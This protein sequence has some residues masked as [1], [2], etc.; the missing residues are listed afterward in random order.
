MI[1]NYFKIAWRN[2]SKNKGYSAINIGGLSVGMA[3]AMLIGLWIWDELSFDKYHKNY[4]RIAR[5]MQNQ[6]YNGEVSSQFANP[7]V[8]SREIRNKYGSDFKYVLQSSWNFQH[9][10]AYGEKKLLKSGSFFEPGIADMLSLKIIKGTSKELKDP[11]SIMISESVAKAYFGDEDPINKTLKLDNKADL[12]VTTIYEDLPYNTTFRELTFILPWELYLI[13]NPWIKKME[14]PWGSNFTQ[15][16]A[17][18]ADNSDMAKVSDKIK[19]VK[20]DVVGP[21]EKKFNAKIFLQP[22]KNWHLRADFKN[23]ELQVTVPVHQPER[24]SR[25]IPIGD[26]SSTEGKAKRS[27]SS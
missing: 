6:T 12:K 5:V 24:K 9:T 21:E 2:L 27:A 20:F 19:N 1:K 11:Y 4:D 8:L 10:L 15:T 23:G 7:A 16:F 26:G 22:M 3:V 13:Q 18:M 14:N 17:L 25:Q